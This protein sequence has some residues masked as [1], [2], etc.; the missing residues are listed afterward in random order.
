MRDPHLA[1]SCSRGSVFSEA[2]Q[3]KARCSTRLL[4]VGFRTVNPPVLPVDFRE[5]DA[6]G[7]VSLAN[8]STRQFLERQ[9]IEL[10][11]GLDIRLCQPLRSADGRVDWK[12]ADARAHFANHTGRWVAEL[13][14]PAIRSSVA[15]ADHWSRRIPPDWLGPLA[16]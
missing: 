13:L 7:R 14:S 9:G 8:Q 11:D 16:G 6:E 12:T 3:H 5:T 15:A 10:V 2:S 4:A 1:P